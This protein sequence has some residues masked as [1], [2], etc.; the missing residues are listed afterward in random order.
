MYGF[1]TYVVFEVKMTRIKW[2]YTYWQRRLLHRNELRDNT[3]GSHFDLTAGKFFSSYLFICSEKD[4]PPPPH[5]T[6]KILTVKLCT[7][8]ISGMCDKLALQFRNAAFLQ[9]CCFTQSIC[10]LEHKCVPTVRY[11]NRISAVACAPCEI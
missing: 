6:L 10:S 9:E 8:S 7:V 11:W 5:H 3:P 1:N 4:P 2:E